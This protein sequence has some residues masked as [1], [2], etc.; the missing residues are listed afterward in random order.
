MKQAPLTVVETAPF[1]RK[2][3]RLLTV[4]QEVDLVDFL[5]HN[6]TAGVLVQGTGGVRKLRWA[7]R[8][9]G[10]REGV[11]VVYYFHSD[12]MPLYLFT[13]FGKGEQD[14]LSNTEKNELRKVVQAIVK[15]HGL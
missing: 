13:V 12:R 1:L 15:S 11:R 8:G 14:S 10:K 5:A 4:R 3:G 2:V 6:P 7:G 9:R